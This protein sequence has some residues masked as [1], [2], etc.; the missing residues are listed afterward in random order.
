[1]IYYLV[2]TSAAHP[3]LA[4]GV[5]PPGLLSAAEENAFRALRS[6]KR[7]HDWLLGRW[8]AKHLIQKLAQQEQGR[9]AALDSF[10]IANGPGGE[11]LLIGESF[12]GLALS[13]SHRDEFA[14]CAVLNPKGLQDPSGFI[15]V[16]IERVEPRPSNFA[17]DYLT[18]PELDLLERSPDHVHDLLVTAIWSAKESALKALHLGLTVDTRAINCAVRPPGLEPDVWTPL[19]ISCKMAR[20]NERTPAL[21]GWW[22]VMQ[23]YVLTVVTEGRVD[24]TICENADEP[25]ESPI[26]MVRPLRATRG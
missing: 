20:L 16:D 26:G 4:Q 10:S 7:R 15:G 25:C 9:A 14:F 8:T 3:D 21:K 11:P 12:G 6:T 17:Q 18:G 22:R 19:E 24:G 5:P 13:I 23:Q 2:Q 1:L